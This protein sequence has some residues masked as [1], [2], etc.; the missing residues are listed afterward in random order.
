MSDVIDNVFKDI[1]MYESESFKNM[2]V[3]GLNIPDKHIDL[4]SL[5][6]GLDMGL[7]EITEIDGNASVNEVKVVNN[8][9]TPLLLLDG[10]EIIGSMQ[11]RI[12]NSTII[13]PAESEKIIPVSCVEAGRWNSNSTKFHYSNNMA[14]SRVR[15]DKLNSVS[16]SLRNDR[17]FESNQQ[18]VWKNISTRQDELKIE[19]STSALHDIYTCKRLDIED[20]MKAF[21]THEKQNG[22]IV[23]I[24][25]QLVG[26]EIIYNSTRYKEYHEKILRS[27]ILDAIGKSDQKYDEKKIDEDE[28]INKIKLANKESFESVGLGTDYRIESKDLGGSV[29]LYENNLINASVF[30][31]VES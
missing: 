19:S 6:I 2:T 17:S 26:F 14:T 29:I 22:L 10:E 27:Y 15:R 12:I 21:S 5:E 16:N 11:N 25:G 30:M 28:L 18:E 24:N 13:I 8:A 3:I 4:M 7:V 1:K 31:K 9:N 20:Y 23:Y